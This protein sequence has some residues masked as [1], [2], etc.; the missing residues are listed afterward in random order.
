VAK[1]YAT[2]AAEVDN[3][4]SRAERFGMR[5]RGERALDFG[6]GAGRLTRPLATRFELVDGVD[7]APGMLELAARD[8]PVASRCRF[9][10][11]S[12]PDLALFE[13]AEFDLVY[14]SVVLQHLS[15]GLAR[16]YLAEF[17]RV[18]RPGGSLIFQLPTRPRWTLR[19]VLHRCLPPPVLGFIQRRLLGYPAPMRMHGMPERRVRALLARH[20]VEVVAT[21]PTRYAPDW[22]ER[23]YFCR[24]LA[25]PEQGQ[26]SNT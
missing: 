9:L 17:A 21:E 26:D 2:G 20:G 22:H 15:R 13:A 19:G 6:C 11:N 1:F 23:R 24:R 8:N 4:L 18:L 5:V 3:V 7:I 10:L 16:G 12:R 25:Q 14:T